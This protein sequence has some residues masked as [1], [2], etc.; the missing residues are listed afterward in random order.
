MY[1]KSC[2][3]RC[4]LRATLSQPFAHVVFSLPPLDAHLHLFSYQIIMKTKS[5]CGTLRICRCAAAAA[6]HRLLVDGTPNRR[7]IQKSQG[8][9]S[10]PK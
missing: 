4:V 10:T 5:L 9:S 8:I 1:K 6:E 7:R 3:R 2:T